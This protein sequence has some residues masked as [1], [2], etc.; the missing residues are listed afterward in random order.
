MS[1]TDK[2][3]PAKDER[4]FSA[5]PEPDAE[6][7]PPEPKPARRGWLEMP[8]G[9]LGFFVLLL[10]AAACGGLIAVYWPWMTGAGPDNAAMADRIGALENRLGQIASGQAPEA[11][12]ASFGELQ[13]KIAALKDRVDADEA[14]LTAVEQAPATAGSEGGSDVSALKAALDKNS[15]DIAQLSQQVDKLA[16]APGA[17]AGSA[18][19]SQLAD[20]LAADEKTM[21]ALRND[22]DAQTK[23]TTAALDKLGERIAALE[24]TAPPADLAQTLGA[25]N[26]RVATLEQNAPPPDLAQRLDSLATKAE[27][28]ALQARV[29]H[30][31]DQDLAGLMRRAASVLALADLVR[32]SEREEPFANELDALRAV[33]PDA[34]EVADLSRYAKTGVPSVATLAARFGARIDPILD[35]ERQA[36][37]HNWFARVWARLVGVVSVRRVGN[38]PGKDTQARVARAEFALKHGDL[39]AAVGEVKA[40]DK[41]ARAAAAAWLTDAEGRLAVNRDA[42]ALTN[43]IVTELEMSRARPAAATGPV[44]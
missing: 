1:D 39:A 24:K 12:A 43:K 10:L 35:A 16:A 40:L 6:R 4:A 30:L 11:A 42:R 37:A 13:R 17:A 8:D 27:I 5:V 44:Q 20:K 7:S 23:A 29:G 31:E 41:P 18:A 25:L 15:S 22:L 2:S 19:N 33:I 26:T 36:Q 9:A 14:R 32:A 38:V 21:A 3:E 28:D 34:P